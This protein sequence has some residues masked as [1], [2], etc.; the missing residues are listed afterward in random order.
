MATVIKNFSKDGID[1]SVQKVSREDKLIISGDGNHRGG[2]IVTC[3]DHNDKMVRLIAA[4]TFHHC[5]ASWQVMQVLEKAKASMAKMDA[6]AGVE[7]T[8]NTLQELGFKPE[9]DF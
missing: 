2:Y 6:A 9:K 8:L 4:K 5:P 3:G 7:E 1:I